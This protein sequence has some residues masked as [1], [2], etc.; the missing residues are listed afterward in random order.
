MGVEEDFGEEVV[1]FAHKAASYGHVALEGGAGGILM[2]HDG[3]EDQCGGKGYGQRVGD[4]GV[5][6]GKGVFFDMEVQA[7]VDVAEED[8]GEVVA[9][10]DDDGVF[11]AEV[12]QPCEGGAEH[13]VGGG[14]GV[15]AGGVE[16]GQAG[17]D[18][19]YVAEYGRGRQHWQHLA[20]GFDGVFDGGGVDYELGLEAAYFFEV[21]EALAVEGE[22]QALRVG[23]VYGDF[24]FEGQQVA[25]EGAHFA[26]AE[27]QYLH[28]GVSVWGGGGYSAE[29][30]LAAVKDLD[31][32]AYGLFVYGGE[33]GAHEVGAHAHL[34]GGGH[35]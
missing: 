1:V 4:G 23:V 16:F 27:Y 20:E 3:A 14:K 9:F 18:G 35:A 19:C 29:V 8:F 15:S 28:C 33:H 32:L 22:A 5:V 31:L 10:G 30:W 6:L 2:L 7:A 13:G 34:D 21:A 17:L 26:G 25:E 24:V 11:V 12:V